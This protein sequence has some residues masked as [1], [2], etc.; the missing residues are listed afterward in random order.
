MPEMNSDPQDIAARIDEILGQ[1]PDRLVNRTTKQP[2]A[3][4]GRCEQALRDLIQSA[5]RREGGS[6]D[7]R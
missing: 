3:H 2:S 7:P 6:D 1:Y 4:G 5:I